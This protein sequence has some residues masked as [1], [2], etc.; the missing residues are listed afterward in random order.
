MTRAHNFVDMTGSR[1]GN[2]VVLVYDGYHAG[3]GRWICECDCG[4]RKS[5]Y[6]AHLRLGR[7]RSCGCDTANLIAAAVV[8]HGHARGGK[9]SREH[10]IWRGMI[11]RCTNPNRRGFADYGGRGIAVCER[12]LAFENFIAD[13]GPAPVGHSID[14]IDNNGNYEPQNCRWADA[15]T[16]AANRRPRR[17][18]A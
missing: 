7:T 6:G 3:G 5:I 13:M 9:V 15:K 4:A 14:R 18:A 11:T 10:A 17:R 8:R 12:W 1:F 2:L 16:Q